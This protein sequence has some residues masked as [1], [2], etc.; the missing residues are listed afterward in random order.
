MAAA[1]V[2][3]FNREIKDTDLLRAIGRVTVTWGQ[4][5]ET[6]QTLVLVSARINVN[7]GLTLIAGQSTIE[8][9]ETLSA[10]LS[11]RF[12]PEVV[13]KLNG[14]RAAFDKLREDRNKVVHYVWT[15]GMESGSH[16][17]MNIMRRAA[18]RGVIMADLD[19]APGIDAIADAI[20]NFDVEL[21]AILAEVMLINGRTK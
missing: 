21:R 8:L 7:V 3:E 20:H 12:P 6:I 4:V 17:A 13:S 11:R 10:L 18:R 5:E 14:L 9:W 1:D 15:K 2:G 19:G 16:V